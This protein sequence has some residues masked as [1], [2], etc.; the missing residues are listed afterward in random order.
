MRQPALDLTRYHWRHEHG[1]LT[2]YGTWWLG[3]DSGPRPC[4]VLIPTHKQHWE[5]AIP[6]VVMMDDAWRWSEKIG[7]PADAAR[8][9]FMFARALGLDINNVQNV[10][11]VRS[12][13]NDHLGDLLGI[14]PMPNSMREMVVIGEVK[15]TD[16]EGGTVIAHDE[17]VERV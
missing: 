13:I 8:Q 17:V 14:P 12:I 2:V 9:A 4:L 5:K 1:D 11:R 15:V 3:L 10:F 6:C 16:R 7:D